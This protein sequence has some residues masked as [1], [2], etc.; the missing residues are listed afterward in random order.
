[1]SCTC[2]LWSFL[3]DSGEIT[4]VA[5]AAGET[6]D[7]ASYEVCGT[8]ARGW[9]C[10]GKKSDHVYTNWALG[11]EWK[12]HPQHLL[13]WGGPVELNRFPVPTLMVLPPPAGR[14]S[15]VLVTFVWAAM[16]P[17]LPPLV[18]LGQ[19]RDAGCD[20]V[21][22]LG[23]GVSSCLPRY[24]RSAL[25]LDGRDCLQSRV[26]WGLPGTTCCNS[27]VHLISR[28]DNHDYPLL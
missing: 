22:G 24:Q 11:P 14:E 6:G 25:V 7:S 23:L 8:S 21:E 20:L 27:A 3:G 2:V 4:C 13:G 5:A 18:T 9:L 16:T 1:M 12:S 15:C 10:R 26:T 19:G 28:E 17:L